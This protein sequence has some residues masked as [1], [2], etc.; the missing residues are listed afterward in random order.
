VEVECPILPNYLFQN[1][2]SASTISQLHLRAC[3][4]SQEPM[5]SEHTLLSRSFHAYDPPTS[6]LSSHRQMPLAGLDSVV[7]PYPRPVSLRS[8]GSLHSLC[9]TV[10]VCL[11][12]GGLDFLHLRNTLS[13]SLARRLLLYLSPTSVISTMASR[14]PPTTMENTSIP[15]YDRKSLA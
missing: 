11:L 12:L 5:P 10:T 1:P 15:F 9:T 7:P 2:S 6:S 8:L 13:F 4:I 14:A 3:S